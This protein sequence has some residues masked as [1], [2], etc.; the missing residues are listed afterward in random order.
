MATAPRI[1][2]IPSP[3]RVDE[4]G[5]IRVGPTR[6]TLD[7]VIGAFLDGDSAED[8]AHHYPALELA[9]VY[10]TITYYLAHRDELDAYLRAEAAETA[11]LRREMEAR[12]DTRGLRE[13]LL[14][15]RSE[16]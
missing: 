3:L 8:I 4:G 9:D 16:R 15:R 10:G 11:Q 5:I 6:V 7:T 12:F 13:R 1:E 14:R 2:S